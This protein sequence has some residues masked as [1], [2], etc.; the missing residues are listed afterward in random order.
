MDDSDCFQFAHVDSL[1]LPLLRTDPFE[2]PYLPDQTA[3]W[4]FTVAHR[5]D[6]AAYQQLMDR[7]FRRTGANLYQPVCPDCHACVPI[8]VPVERF[9]PTRSQRRVRRRN[10]DVVWT[11]S[12]PHCDDECAVL[13]GRY[14]RAVHG[15]RGDATA[16]ELNA[17]L[18][19]SPVDTLQFT[20]RLSGRLIGVGLVDVTPAALSSVYFVYD[21]DESW[22]S[23]GVFSGLCEIDECRRRG[24]PH[25]YIGYHV[26]GCRKMEYKS[27]F[28]PYELLRPDGVWRE[29]TAQPPSSGCRS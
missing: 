8:R 18:F 4:R 12:G 16:A 14:E 19:A 29:P 9:K 20:Y 28:R 24:L 27:R 7:R 17:S 13:F 21:P 22:R 15:K 26:A 1:R 25:W 23:L 3:V 11:V 10:T 6:A 5:F 2:C